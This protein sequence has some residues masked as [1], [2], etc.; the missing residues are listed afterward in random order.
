MSEDAKYKELHEAATEVL[1]KLQGMEQ[2]MGMMQSA[3]SYRLQQALGMS[4]VANAA[5]MRYGIKIG[6]RP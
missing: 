1:M 3:E 2:R 6:P 5:Q 4:T